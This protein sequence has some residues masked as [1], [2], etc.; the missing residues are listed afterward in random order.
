MA[1]KTAKAAKNAVSTAR[2][3]AKWKN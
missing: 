1:G 3:T 2:S